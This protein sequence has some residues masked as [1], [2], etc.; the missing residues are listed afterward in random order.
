[1]T[2]RTSDLAAAKAFI[3]NASLVLI[4]LTGNDF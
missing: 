3:A 2:F 1:M 4:R